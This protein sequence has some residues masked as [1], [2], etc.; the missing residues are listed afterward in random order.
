MSI[1]DCDSEAPSFFRET[2]VN[3][4]KEHKCCECWRAIKPGDEYQCIVG[5]WE[6]NLSTFKSCERCGDL[7]EALGEVVCP[8]FGK[9]KEAYWG[10]LELINNSWGK[11]DTYYE[12]A[13]AKCKTAYDR[14]FK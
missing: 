14:V 2:W 11:S 8:E 3:A 1:C 10:Y 7:R 9:L 13:H 4:R 12:L 5:F 6:G